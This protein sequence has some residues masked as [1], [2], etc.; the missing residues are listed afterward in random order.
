MSKKYL[1]FICFLYS[2]ITIYVWA[3]GILK[4]FLAPNMQMYLKVSVFIFIMMG[5]VL[6]FNNRVN[7]KFKI[8]D[9]VLLLPLVLIVLSGDGRLT[10]SLANNRFNNFN[11]RNNSEEVKVITPDDEEYYEEDEELQLPDIP[12]ERIQIPNTKPVANDTDK[13][14]DVYFNVVDSSYVDLASYISFDPS[15]T[16]YAGKGIRIRGFAVLESP[17]LPD[18]DWFLI[19]KYGTNC[20]AA[21]AS[22]AGWYAKY[23]LSK[24]EKDKWYQVEGILREG[25]DKDGLQIMY[26]EVVSME[27]IDGS[28]EEQYVWPCYTYDDGKCSEIQKYNL[29]Y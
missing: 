28:K 24:V 22:F 21:D 2:G 25:K 9:L 19:G 11:N 13:K 8:T 5:L 14:V 15:A 18:G 1:G 3:S 27:E 4:N 29:E 7:Y 16:K 23:D 17:F 10:A 20:C 12:E 6:I 26:V